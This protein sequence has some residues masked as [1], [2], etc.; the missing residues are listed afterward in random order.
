MIWTGS[1]PISPD[2][3]GA[4]VLAILALAIASGVLLAEGL[5]RYDRH[6]RRVERRLRGL[7][8]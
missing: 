2:M 5:I 4:A 8:P 3:F 6:R 1:G 7:R